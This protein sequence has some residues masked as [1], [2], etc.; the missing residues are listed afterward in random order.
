MQADPVFACHF[1]VVIAP[2]APSS[3]PASKC[4]FR[5]TGKLCHGVIAVSIAKSPLL[6]TTGRAR[7]GNEE[8]SS[9]LAVCMHARTYAYRFLKLAEYSQDTMSVY[10]QGR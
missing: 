3:Q 9:R 5:V 1:C 10:V 4:G 6:T 8:G 7:S 2:P